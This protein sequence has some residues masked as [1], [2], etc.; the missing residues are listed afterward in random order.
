MPE[1][2]FTPVGGKRLCVQAPE[3]GSLAD[4]C[5]DV[6]APVTFACRGATCGACRVW[7]L[8]GALLLVPPE[9][10][11]RERLEAFESA[12]QAAPPSGGHRLAC[13]A[14]MHARSGRLVLR[15]ARVEHL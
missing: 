3:G 4:L 2:I 11:E 10:D 1:V 12:G 5:D 7:V 15:P 6:E 8:E 9:D 14:T 13:Q